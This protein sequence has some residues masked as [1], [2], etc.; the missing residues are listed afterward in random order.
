MDIAA[1]EKQ[2]SDSFLPPTLSRTYDGDDAYWG[3]EGGELR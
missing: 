1:L 3:K 2:K